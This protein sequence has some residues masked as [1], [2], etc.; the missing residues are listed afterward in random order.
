[1]N[2]K[3]F[4]KISVGTALLITSATFAAYAAGP[5][6]VPLRGTIAYQDA[7][8]PTNDP[9]CPISGM[10]IGTGTVSHLGK[11]A[12]VSTAC[13][14]VNQ[15]VYTILRSTISVT[16][17]NG[18]MLTGSYTGIF[19]PT[20]NGTLYELRNGTLTITGGTGQFANATGSGTL[21]TT[22]D[23]ATGQGTTSVIATI[24][25]PH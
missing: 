22:E 17:A 3:P 12:A 7:I 2:L 19:Y 20:G 6:D 18:D 11:S 23:L 8:S 21:F 25:Y 14:S 15:G 1:M 5:S 10:T 13:I 24:S 4:R 9:N 16:A